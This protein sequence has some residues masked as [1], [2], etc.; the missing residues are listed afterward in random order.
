M[1]LGKKTLRQ[2]KAFCKASSH[3]TTQDKRRIYAFLNGCS[4]SLVGMPA[5]GKTTIGKKL[6]ICLEY[7][8]YDSDQEIEKAAAKT[9]SE[10]FEDEGEEFFRHKE[11][12]IIKRLLDDHTCILSL[13]GGAC[14]RQE[15]RD[16]LKKNTYCIWIQAPLHVLVRNA[17]RKKSRPLFKH[18]NIEAKM[19]Q[20]LAERCY[21]F[22]AIS[23]QTFFCQND[24]SVDEA[25]YKIVH[26]LRQEASKSQEANY[27][28]DIE[29][30]P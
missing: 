13:G 11:Q 14:L 18:G 29:G 2:S 27:N 28:T 9:I 4:I 26:I 16:I 1:A 5:V 21:Y 19:K 17:K 15:T 3:I 8:F 10:I 22:N 12:Q 24:V 30:T 20:L 25:V 7:P 6:A 23:H